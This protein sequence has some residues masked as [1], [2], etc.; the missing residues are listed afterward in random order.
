MC[1]VRNGFFPHL[2]E[3]ENI[4]IIVAF[5]GRECILI[6]SDGE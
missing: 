6:S 5:I 4:R 1:N 2:V 3:S